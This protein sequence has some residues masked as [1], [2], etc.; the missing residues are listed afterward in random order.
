[1]NKNIIIAIVALIV[2]VGG[3]MLIG[4]DTQVLPTDN[5]FAGTPTTTNSSTTVNVSATGS[6]TLEII[7][8]G[9]WSQS[10]VPPPPEYRRAYTFPAY[11]SVEAKAIVNAE[12]AK[13]I[14]QIDSDKTNMKAWIELGNQYNL[15]AD[16]KGAELFWDYA[17]KLNPDNFLPYANLGTLYMSDLKDYAKAELNLKLAIK[18]DPTQIMVYRSLY[19]L[20][21][22]GLGDDVKAKAILQAGIGANSGT[23]QD[24]KYLLDH[25]TEQ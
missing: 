19:E 13:L 7:P 14:A 10:N 21:R 1:M 12:I 25:Y 4:R 18:A 17:V 11:F 5:P 20:Y 22:F 24:L 16:Y 23:A 9:S 3:Y 8:L 15:V 2:I 6:S